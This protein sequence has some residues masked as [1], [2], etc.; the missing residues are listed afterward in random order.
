VSEREM[1][2]LNPSHKAHKSPSSQ[3][4]KLTIIFEYD[5]QYLREIDNGDF[6]D[7][8]VWLFIPQ[9]LFFDAPLRTAASARAFRSRQS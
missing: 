5:E 7:Q 2:Y 9:I 6:S 8:R 3:V 4:T 1:L